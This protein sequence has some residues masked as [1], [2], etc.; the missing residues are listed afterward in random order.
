MLPV[1]GSFPRAAIFRL[2]VQTDHPSQL[3]SVQQ[4]IAW[5]VSNYADTATYLGTP[6][7]EYF[8]TALDF[9]QVLPY[10]SIRFQVD[11]DAPTTTDE[12]WLA[13][14]WL[15]NT[16][17]TPALAAIRLAGQIND[18]ARVTSAVYPDMR[19]L[20]A[21]AVGGDVNI[22]LPW[23]M[24]GNSGLGA[25]DGPNGA[26]SAL[27]LFAGVDNPLVAGIIGPKRHVFRVNF[28]FSDPYYGEPPIA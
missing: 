9:H 20:N 26:E 28:P 6:A 25:Q 19:S 8:V 2:G 1:P 18:F 14:L 21:R 22:Y 23:G 16:D 5:T 4:G 24:I 12:P 7:N 15:E 13:N 27:I 17:T 10:T 3:Q 11:I